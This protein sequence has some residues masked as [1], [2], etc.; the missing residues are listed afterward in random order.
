MP[1]EGEVPLVPGYLLGELL[2]H[3]LH[4]TVWRATREASGEGVA[5]KVLHFEPDDR[6]ARKRQELAARADCRHLVGIH[7]VVGL[8]DGRWATVMD[9]ADGGSLRDVVSVRG[10]LPP[11]EVV[12]VLTP[13]AS[14]LDALHS[15]G[16]VHAD[17]SPGNVLFTSDGVPM[18]ADL[19]GARALDDYEPPVVDGTPGFLAPEVAEGGMP[20]PASDVWSLG[21][22]AWYALTGGSVPGAGELGDDVA[23]TVGPAFAQLLPVLLAVEPHARPSAA[24]AAPVIYAAAEARPVRL[25]GRNIDPATALTRRIRREAAP[26]A[27]SRAEAKALARAQRRRSSTARWRRLLSL[28]RVVLAVVPAVVVLVS[29]AVAGRAGLVRWTDSMQGGT[30]VSAAPLSSVPSSTRSPVATTPGAAAS[31]STGAGTTQVAV[32]S[33]QTAAVSTPAAA[34]STPATAASTPGAVA[35]TPGAA[36]STGTAVFSTPRA[37]A[38]VAPVDALRADPAGAVQRLLDARASA[39]GSGRQERLAEALVPGSAAFVDDARTLEQ[40]A[41]HQQAYESLSYTVGSAQVVGGDATN[42]QVRA[43]VDRA[44]YTVS[45]PGAARQARPALHGRTFGYLLTLT[46][47]GWRLGAITPI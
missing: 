26:S 30:A 28:R 43:V 22:L 18:L 25:A 41:G 24:Q 47:T 8:P 42:V 37:P 34:A 13:V 39:L 35:S 16:V 1:H 4:G 38:S 5:V 40:L 15:V 3:G 23:A 29:L 20:V 2:G 19:D 12:T 11:Q 27:A 32:A 14:A 33:T 46:D 9:L 36:A 45:G 6:A 31:T 21:A 7:E 10:P 44:P 17:V